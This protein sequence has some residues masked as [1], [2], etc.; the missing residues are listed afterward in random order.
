LS[1]SDKDLVDLVLGDLR[2]YLKEM[3][4]GFDYY[5]LNTLQLRAMN[6]EYKIKN[7]K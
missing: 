1:I 5:N 4:K 2:S 6:Q 7:S 3:L